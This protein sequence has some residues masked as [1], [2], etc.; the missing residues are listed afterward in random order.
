MLKLVFH[1]WRRVAAALVMGAGLASSVQAQIDPNLSRPIIHIAYSLSNQQNNTV[2]R[3]LQRQDRAFIT[4]SFPT[5]GAGSG[6]YED[7]PAPLVLSPDKQFLCAVNPGS[8]TVSLFKVDTTNGNLTLIGQAGASVPFGA[9]PVGVAI[10]TRNVAYVVYRD[11]G[12]SIAAFRLQATGISEISSSARSLFSPADALQIA[13]SPNADVLVVS[14]RTAGRLASFALDATGMP[15]LFEQ[16]FPAN[17]P[18]GLA[19]NRRDFL[20]ATDVQF[21]GLNAFTVSSAGEV[22]GVNAVGVGQTTR[23]VVPTQSDKFVF[24]S[25]PLE[26]RIARFN[27]DTLT[28]RVSLSQAVAATTDQWPFDLALSPKTSTVPQFLY[29]LNRAALDTTANQSIQV[30]SV[31]N[32]TGALSLVSTILGV[33]FTANGL[34]ALQ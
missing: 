12:T 7:V 5:G 23:A 29:A 14:Q 17:A 18:F 1:V 8:G 21:G 3:F 6:V 26:R 19:F 30:F 34:V 11:A 31:D 10:S 24:V 32:T 28:G 15:S 16:D 2:V 27:T 33:P 25:D 13:V 22:S 20:F 4:T 9:T